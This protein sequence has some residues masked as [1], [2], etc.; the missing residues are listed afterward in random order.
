MIRRSSSSKFSS[1]TSPQVENKRDSHQDEFY[2][3]YFSYYTNKKES[4]QNKY[5]I[6]MSCLY[7]F[8]FS[9]DIYFGFLT[10]SFLIE[11]F[12]L[13]FQGYVKLELASVPPIIPLV[14]TFFIP[15]TIFV[16]ISIA[17]KCKSLIM[18]YRENKATAH[19]TAL[20]STPKVSATPNTDNTHKLSTAFDFSNDSYPSINNLD[21]K[22]TPTFLP[23]PGSRE[24]SHAGF[25]GSFQD[26]YYQHPS[27]SSHILGRSE[28]L[29]RVLEE[30]DDTV[31]RGRRLRMHHHLTADN[32][33]ATPLLIT[34]SQ[35]LP[36]IEEKL[37]EFNFEYLEEKKQSWSERLDVALHICRRPFF[38]LCSCVGLVTNLPAFSGPEIQNRVICLGVSLIFLIGHLTYCIRDAHKK[39]YERGL[40]SFVIGWILIVNVRLG[41]CSLNPLF[42]GE[43]TWKISLF[44]LVFCLVF[45][46]VSLT[47]EIIVFLW[48]RWILQ[49]EQEESEE[50][51]DQERYEI[52]ENEHVTEVTEKRNS[53]FQILYSALSRG[54]SFGCLL[55]VTHWLFTSGTTLVRWS[56]FPGFPYNLSIVAALNLGLI[57][58]NLT[59]IL[60]SIV[61]FVVMLSF[62]FMLSYIPTNDTSYS[63]LI[64]MASIVASLVLPS[65]WIHVLIRKHTGYSYAASNLSAALCCATGLFIYI[66]QVILLE[67]S[68]PSSNQDSS[69]TWMKFIRKEAHALL[70][71]SCVIISTFGI[72]LGNIIRRPVL[73]RKQDPLSSNPLQNPN[74]GIA[75]SFFKWFIRDDGNKKSRQS[76]FMHIDKRILAVVVIVCC[77]TLFP[78]VGYRLFYA[79]VPINQSKDD[80]T[81]MTFNVHN[82]YD[83]YGRNNFKRVL[84]ILK[85][86]RATV[87]GLQQSDTNRISASNNDLLEYLSFYLNMYEYY[88]P[89]LREGSF[90]C[91]ILSAYPL[92]DRAFYLLPSNDSEQ[93]V[94][95]K[96]YIRATDFDGVEESGGLPTNT[97][98]TDFYFFS[99][100]FSM[101]NRHEQFEQAQYVSRI[102][103][104]VW[105]NNG[106]HDRTFET[107]FLVGDLN[108]ATSDKFFNESHLTQVISNPI[109]QT[110]A[111]SNFTTVDYISMSVREN[112]HARYVIMNSTI[113]PID[114]AISYHSPLVSWFKAIEKPKRKKIF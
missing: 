102:L 113:L 15:C 97:S 73:G 63:I 55:F 96:A 35:K 25:G 43:R 89:S 30:S 20:S 84:D 42:I 52:D 6:L 32:S 86:G 87:I 2:D 10:W 64:L 98:L 104:S 111:S 5:R 58:A 21:K 74:D 9:S 95:V 8:G 36:P 54:V 57:L 91:S 23:I 19:S 110:N 24:S 3:N 46:L 103:K 45:A 47:E 60:R 39:Q 75:T 85:Q 14:S 106:I 93:A 70:I 29:M 100:S 7:W 82:G 48:R 99:S 41:Y 33:P 53:R 90:G 69:V 27:P 17:S 76:P 81:L 38:Y 11:F 62:A 59:L 71:F 78:S 26:Y 13:L 1:L 105:S 114:Q 44:S 68:T 72:G 65:I 112:N 92:E 22:V 80:I 66:F 28:S 67:F 61:G 83:L 101:R 34:S 12:S 4:E 16:L 109:V 94:M 77:L 56:G 108:L 107:F 31:I 50:N 18:S 49:Q 79:K 40:W 51:Q 37:F 88:G